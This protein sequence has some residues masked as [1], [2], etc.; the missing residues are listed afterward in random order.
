MFVMSTPLPASSPQSAELKEDIFVSLFL[1]NRKNFP[2][3]V[4]Q[5][6]ESKNPLE[7]LRLP[8]PD[9][10]SGGAVASIALVFFLRCVSMQHLTLTTC[11]R[12]GTSGGETLGGS[13]ICM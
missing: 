6:F 10:S 5:E 9:M 4:R 2:L 7:T 11:S 1:N 3:T 13:G 8:S 12:V